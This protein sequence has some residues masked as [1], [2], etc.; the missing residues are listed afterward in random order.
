MFAK[1]RSAEV[2]IFLEVINCYSTVFHRVKITSGNFIL[3][4]S[5][6]QALGLAFG[7]S[8]PLG[9]KYGP[10]HGDDQFLIFTANSISFLHSPDDQATSRHLVTLFSNFMRAG[11]PNIGEE[12]ATEYNWK[13]YDQNSVRKHSFRNETIVFFSA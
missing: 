3:L 7:V 4:L 12:G 8:L 9:R 6:I 11:N 5:H 13:R 2:F 1:I 10:C